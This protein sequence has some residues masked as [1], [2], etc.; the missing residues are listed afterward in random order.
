M[1]QQADKHRPDKNFQV[2]DLVY[3]KLQPYKQKSVVSR[4][5]L[6]LSARFFSPY[7]ILEKIGQVAYK[8]DLP[9][10]SKIHLVFHVS[11]LKK[12]VGNSHVQSL[13]PPLDSDGLIVKEPVQILDQRMQRVGNIAVIETLV[14]LSNTFPKYATWENWSTLQEQFPHFHP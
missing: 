14:R 8:L 5:C 2:G 11:Q 7:A 4:A 10:E 13:P 1:K 9:A 6:K 3:L 12:H